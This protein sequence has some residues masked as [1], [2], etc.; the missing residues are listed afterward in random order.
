[1]SITAAEMR[2]VAEEVLSK[3]EM[4][5]REKVLKHIEE[6]IVPAIKEA[7]GKGEF[8]TICKIDNDISIELVMHELFEYGFK[9]ARNVM[10]L[11]IM[12]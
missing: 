5:K 12:W 3:R 2:A 4:E 10:H 7:S 6:T 8:S 11:R 9:I 1:M